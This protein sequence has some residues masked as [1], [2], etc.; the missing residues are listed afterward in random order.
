MVDGIDGPPDAGDARQLRVVL[1]GTRAGLS[2]RNIATRLYGADRVAAQWACD[3][4]MRAHT[5][6]L[7]NKARALAEQGDRDLP[8]AR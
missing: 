7:V 5:P 3:S 6:R 4:R 2:A 1:D 8:P